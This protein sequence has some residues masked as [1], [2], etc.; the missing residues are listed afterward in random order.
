MRTCGFIGCKERTR[1]HYGYDENICGD[2]YCFTAIERTTKLIVAW[3]LGKRS[4]GDTQDFADILRRA[5]T[6]RFQLT[7]DGYSPYQRAIPY[8]FGPRIDFATLVK[9]YQTPDD[10]QRRYS[11]A[12]IVGITITVR[13]GD[14]DEDRICT[15]HVERHNRTIRMQV[16]RMT[17]L[18]DAHSKKWENHDAALALF[19]AFYNFCR[20]HSTLKTTPAVKAGISDHVWSLAELLQRAS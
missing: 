20:V 8:T 19:F 16:R 10:G 11:P 2:A 17:R 6:G 5:R 15:S 9:K 12:D 4:P 3:H 14:P 18:T 13:T 7:T 1:Q